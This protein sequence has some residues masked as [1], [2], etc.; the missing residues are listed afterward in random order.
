METFTEQ[1]H[2]P[3]FILAEASGSRSRE[4]G[5]LVTGQNL[6]AGTVV[7]S[8]G[9]GKLTAYTAE[10]VTDGGSNEAVGILLYPVNATD[11]DVRCSYLARDAEVNLKALVYPDETTDGDQEAHTIASLKL[12]NIICR[13]DG[14]DAEI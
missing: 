9:S 2:G 11:E 3:E 13:D 4:N 8:N 14:A 12:L 5:T 6:A 1:A 10:D 7:M